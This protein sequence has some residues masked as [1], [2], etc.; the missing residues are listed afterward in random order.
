M[1]TTNQ[2]PMGLMRKYRKY[3]IVQ[4]CFITHEKEAV[5]VHVL[6]KVLTV[7]IN[8]KFI[9]HEIKILQIPRLW[10]VRLH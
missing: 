3:N 7:F 5:Y 8:D 2:H 6:C 4:A 1:I 10:G 9:A